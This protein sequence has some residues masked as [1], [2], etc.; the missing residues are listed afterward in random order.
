MGTKA[1]LGGLLGLALTTSMLVG[2]PLGASSADATSRHFVYVQTDDP[3]GNAVAVYRRTSTG[4]LASTGTFATGGLGGALGGA[5]VDRLASQGSVTFDQRTK[6]LYVVNAG[7]DSLTVFRQDGDGLVRRQVVD[8]GGDFPVS[9]T[10]HGSIVYVL[11]A[12]DG[13]SVQGFRWHHGSL[14]R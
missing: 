8:T 2:G 10:V 3:A 9:V 1:R 13:G 14:H 7:S 4:G 12:R 5:Q 11:N 6:L